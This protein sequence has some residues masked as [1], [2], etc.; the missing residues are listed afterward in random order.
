MAD[1]QY[2]ILPISG[3]NNARQISEVVN[4]SMQGKTNNTGTLTL[5]T[6]GTTTTLYDERIGFNSVILLSPLNINSAG[7][8]NHIFV[9]SKSKG[10]AVI[11][12]RNHGHTDVI[13]DY[14]IVG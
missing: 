13:L 14:I 12:H 5:E 3:S 9:Q 10:S 4:N 8:I 11:G 2:R 1:N 7:E 6:S